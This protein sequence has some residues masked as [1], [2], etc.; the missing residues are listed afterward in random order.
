MAVVAGWIN[1]ES[2]VNMWRVVRRKEKK[3]KENEPPSMHTYVMHW[4]HCGD[5]EGVRK[6]RKFELV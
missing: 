3:S 6:K 5:V 4:G 1:D 2:L